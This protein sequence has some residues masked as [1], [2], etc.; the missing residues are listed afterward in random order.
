MVLII[1]LQVCIPLEHPAHLE[2]LP[3]WE[4]ARLETLE[5][6]PQTAAKPANAFTTPSG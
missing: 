2:V 6:N 3:L 1:Q 4:R 5:A